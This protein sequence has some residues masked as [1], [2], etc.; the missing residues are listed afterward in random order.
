MR[1]HKWRKYYSKPPKQDRFFEWVA[2]IA[3]LGLVLIALDTYV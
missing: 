3:L 1:K 2:M